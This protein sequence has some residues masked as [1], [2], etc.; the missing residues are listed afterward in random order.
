[1]DTK[2]KKGQIPWNSG[3][4]KITNLE[5]IR[6]CKNCLEQKI[7]T[8]FVKS[9]HLYRYMCKVC[10]KNLRRTGKTNEGRFKK[11]HKIGNRF[12]K[13]STPWFVEKNLPAP[14]KNK[15]NLENKNKFSSFHYKNCRKQV[16]ER[17]GK[18]CVKCNSMQKLHAHHIIPWKDDESKRFDVENGMTLCISCHAKIEGLGTII[19]RKNR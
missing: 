4:K 13:G 14:R 9:K 7:I 16:V 17:D 1:M 6:Q 18:K 11:G 3:Y 10:R 2:F 5:E 8:E 12:A 19:Q 15:H